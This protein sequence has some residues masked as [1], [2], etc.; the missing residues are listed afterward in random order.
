MKARGPLTLRDVLRRPPRAMRVEVEAPYVPPV[1]LGRACLR[2]PDLA[3][4]EE[5]DGITFLRDL[6]KRRLTH[7]RP[8]H[9]EEPSSPPTMATII[10]LHRK[11]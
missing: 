7:D 1:P 6:G 3:E 11:S 10:R 5:Y 2:D 8:P 9:V 4:Y